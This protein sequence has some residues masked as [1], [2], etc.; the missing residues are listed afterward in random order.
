MTR[1]L[2][3][4]LA[5]GVFTLVLVAVIV[6]LATQALPGDAASAILGSSATPQRLAALRA[7][8]HLD[9]P[10]LGQFW[11]W[12]SGL[13]QGHFGTS[14]AARRPVSDVLGTRMLNTLTLV[15]VSAVVGLPL[16]LWLGVRSAVK[17]DRVFDHV[18]SVGTLTL[19]ALPEFV[20]GIALILL[21]ATQVLHLLPAVSLLQPGVPA[22]E[23]PKALVLPAATLVLAVV[24][25]VARIVRGSMIDVLEEEYVQMARLKGLSERV[26]VL[27]YALPNAIAPAIQACALSLAYMTGGVVVVEYVFQ[28]NGIG[29]ALVEA[30]DNRDVPVVQAIVLLIGAVYVLLNIL[31]DVATVLVTPK[32]R[33]QLR[34]ARRPAVEPSLA[35]ELPR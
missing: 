3:S 10:V 16:A 2:A 13:V 21:L 34:R 24:P 17:R 35:T 15:V 12:F 25:Y 9:E 33:T 30:V 5:W 6:F 32:L 11:H 27:R 20:V 7:Q 19:A 23:Q 14:L 1:L 4:R 31:A 29:A 26:V 18:V 28:Y 22:W 8:L